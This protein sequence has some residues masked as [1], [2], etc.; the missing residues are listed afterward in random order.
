MQF[1][2]LLCIL[3]AVLIRKKFWR[4]STFFLLKNLNYHI[5][6]QTILYHRMVDVAGRG[7]STFWSFSGPF[8]ILKSGGEVKGKIWGPKVKHKVPEFGRGFR[9]VTPKKFWILTCNFNWRVL[10]CSASCFIRGNTRGNTY[11][12]STSLPLLLCEGIGYSS[13]FA[14]EL[15]TPPQCRGTWYPFHT[16]GWG[17]RYP[18]C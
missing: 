4:K 6:Y 14:K 10:V 3:R 11:F 9:G 15:G 8:C 2:R 16:W 18:S 7:S 17:Y 1:D 13:R 5:L 12:E